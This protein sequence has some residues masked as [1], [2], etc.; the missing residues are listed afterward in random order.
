MYNLNHKK[1]DDLELGKE[2]YMKKKLVSSVVLVATLAASAVVPAFAE[3]G[4]SEVYWY[5][6]VSGYG[7]ANW[8]T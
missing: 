8:N 5:S 3:E 1:R 2:I 6:D 4:T 7:P